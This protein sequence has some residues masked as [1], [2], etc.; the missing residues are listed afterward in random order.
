MDNKIVIYIFIAFILLLG[1]ILFD[2]AFPELSVQRGI[3]AMMSMYC[4]SF[5]VGLCIKF[6][7][8]DIKNIDD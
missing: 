1:I 7:L 3:A 5:V 8:G 2:Y 6:G 4:F